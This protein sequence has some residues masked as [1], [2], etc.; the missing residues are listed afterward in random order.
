MKDERKRQ[1][2]LKEIGVQEEIGK[3][4]E[5]KAKGEKEAQIQ[6]FA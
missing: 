5:K 3:L 2:D 6:I 4:S 1:R